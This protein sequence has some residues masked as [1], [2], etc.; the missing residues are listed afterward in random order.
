MTSYV[1]PGCGF[2]GYCLP[3]DTQA[4]H[5]LAK[6]QGYDAP[7]LESV[8]KTNSQIKKHLVEKVIQM[9]DR[10]E[11]IGILGLSFKPESDDVRES[12]SKDIISLLLHRGFKKIFVYDPLA[13]EKFM[14]SYRLPVVSLPTLEDLVK[15]CDTLV[16]LTAWDEFWQKR[17]LFREKKVIDGRYFLREATA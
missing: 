12:A 5:H 15:V 13:I 11:S 17:H 4:M 10:R 8:L 2:G 14:D 9:A 1:F 6:Q 7:L 3:K 16:I